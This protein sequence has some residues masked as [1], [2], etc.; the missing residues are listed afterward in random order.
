MVR[1]TMSGFIK[2]LPELVSNRQGQLSTTDATTL[3]ALFVSSL[4]LLITVWRW[5]HEI[6]EAFGLYLGAWVLHAGVQKYHDRKA[7]DDDVPAGTQ[8]GEPDGRGAD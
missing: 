8:G 5:E 3:V 4:A 1:E 7:G 6:V 2:R